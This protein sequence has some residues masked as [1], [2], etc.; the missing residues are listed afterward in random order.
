M[1]IVERTAGD[2]DRLREFAT[3]EGNAGRRDR[4]RAVLL[5]LD[6]IEKLDIARAIG[7]S[8]SFVEDWV[9]GSR[10]ASDP[11]RAL[12]AL[13][14]TKQPGMTPRLARGREREFLARVDE[15]PRES[16]GVCTLRGRDLRRILR[17]EFGADYSE[18]GVCTLMKRLGYSSLTPHPIHE[19][20]DAKRAQDFKESAPSLSATKRRSTKARNS[21]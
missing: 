4:F 6:G 2:R 12:D 15:S 11:A 9:Y 21:A 17:E 20:H 19:K 18:R 7:R 5:A 16:D 1:R 14:P 13:R 8:K 3:R 10:D